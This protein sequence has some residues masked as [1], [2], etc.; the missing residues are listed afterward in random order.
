MF[1]LVMV[2]GWGRGHGS[3][4]RGTCRPLPVHCGM[5]LEGMPDEEGEG[6]R[7]HHMYESSYLREKSEEECVS[8]CKN[9]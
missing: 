3:E 6:W 2:I 4:V 9:D 1:R 8:V 7:S 5:H